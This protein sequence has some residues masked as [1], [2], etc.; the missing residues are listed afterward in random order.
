MRVSTS[1]LLLIRDNIPNVEPLWGLERSLLRLGAKA[2]VGAM[3][4]GAVAVLS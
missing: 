4:V 1:L 3:V 2:G